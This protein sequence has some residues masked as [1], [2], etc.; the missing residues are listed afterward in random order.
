MEYRLTKQREAR[1]KN[2]TIVE[3]RI[4]NQRKQVLSKKVKE[5]FPPAKCKRGYVENSS[6]LGILWIVL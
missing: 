6:R 4:T 1:K 3:K 2:S 5:L